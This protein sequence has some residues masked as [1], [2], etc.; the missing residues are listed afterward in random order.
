MAGPALFL[1]GL[2]SLES[3]SANDPTPTP[4]PRKGQLIEIPAAPEKGFN[5]PYLLFVPDSAEGKN[6]DFLLVEPNNT[7]RTSDD[8]EVHRAAATSLARDSSVG[9]WIAK[10]LRI[11][12]LV[13]IFPRPASTKDVYTHS[14]DRDTILISSGLLKRLDL[15][16]LA[17][18][19]DA[20]PRLEAMK[21]PVRSKVLLNG[22]SASGLFANRFTLLHPDTVAAAAFG[23]INGFITLPVA[24]LRLRPLNFPV[25]VADLEKITGHPFDRPAYQAIPQFGYMGAEETNDALIYPDAYSEEERALIFDLLGR[26]MMPDRWEAVQAVYQTEKVPIQFKTYP[27]IGHGT[28]GRI[29]KE[30]T[31]F[32]RGVIEKNSPQ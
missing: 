10:A 23:G 6:Y 32:F 12:L 3:A 2:L 14:I 9:N 15:Q 21:R 8:F 26:T 22:F 7:G 27:G 19:A 24:E 20:R 16:L 4:T 17:M 18:I 31:E 29:N 11:P 13:P 1:A 28:D 5:F 30:V 25:G